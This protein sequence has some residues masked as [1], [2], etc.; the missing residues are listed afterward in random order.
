MGWIGRIVIAVIAAV[1]AY[2]VCYVLV[3]FLPGLP[4]IGPQV[5]AVIAKFT[6][7]ICLLVFL[8]FLF[9]GYRT[10]PWSGVKF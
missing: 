10:G 2:I 5:A 1:I 8:W 7:V 9:V 3:L 6:Y 4:P